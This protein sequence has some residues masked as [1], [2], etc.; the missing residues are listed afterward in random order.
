MATFWL[1]GIRNLSVL[2]AGLVTASGFYGVADWSITLVIVL[3]LGVFAEIGGILGRRARARDARARAARTAVRDASL[4]R[5]RRRERE[6]DP[7]RNAA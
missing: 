6:R 7:K 5:E 3:A 1:W 2:L 4:L